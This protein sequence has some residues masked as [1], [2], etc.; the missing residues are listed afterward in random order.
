MWVRPR[1]VGTQFRKIVMPMRVALQEGV[2][3]H[4]QMTFS[5][6]LLLGFATFSFAQT[7]VQN[8]DF[9]SW[10][11]SSSGRFED[12][13]PSTTWA[14][15]NYAMD[16]I[17]GNLSTSIVQK[18]SDA[19]SG[20]FSALMKSRNIVGNFV[21]ATLFTGKLDA[22]TPFSPVPLLGIP[23]TGRPVAISGWRKYSP[24]G[25]DSSSMYARLTKWN[26]NTNTRETIAFKEIR[27]YG[28]IGTWTKFDL[29]LD[30]SSNSTPDSIIIVFSASA[31]AEQNNGEVGSSLWIDDV[32]IE[33]PTGVEH[34]DKGGTLVLT[35]NPCFGSIIISNCTE[36]TQFCIFN[37]C[38]Q[39]MLQGSLP[40]VKAAISTLSLVPGNYYLRVYDIAGNAVRTI[41]FTKW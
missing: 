5:L 16:L 15:P 4:M 30:Y 13:S 12:P 19:H 29:L 1:L 34:R 27:D 23:F 25:G 10:T 3:L 26:S 24:V 21:G 6:I 36:H 7:S 28:S 33:Y 14:T 38:G 37:A 22:S 35:P 8:L 17:F 9:E 40:A 41:Q 31:G 39:S 32:N 20:S 11:L 2:Y 18:S